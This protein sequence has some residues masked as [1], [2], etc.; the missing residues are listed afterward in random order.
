MIAVPTNKIVDLGLNPNYS[1]SVLK[2]SGKG[3]LELRNSWG[4]VKERPNVSLS[5][6][7]VF[8]FSS[9]YAH[10]YISHIMIAHTDSDLC[11][12]TIQSKHHNSF[13]SAYNFTVNNDTRG[14]I[15]ISQLD[16]RL[17]SAKKSYQYSPMR[18][19]IVKK[20]E[21]GESVYVN[22]GFSHHSKN[23]DM[24][25][26]LTT[27]N[28]H[29]YCIGQWVDQIYDYYITI[30]CYQNVDLRKVYFHNFPNIIAESLTK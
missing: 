15:S 26:N 20:T 21:E 6:E 17:F 29:I 10:D 18:V 7:G 9:A 16:E 19:I 4:T 30:S 24:E 22:A 2:C 14:F 1:F 5:R 8:E 13:Y 11:T 25:V 27:G 23:L 3:A 12:T 28:Y